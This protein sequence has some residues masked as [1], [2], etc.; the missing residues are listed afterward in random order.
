[1]LVTIF[2]TLYDL[3]IHLLSYTTVVVSQ[4][5]WWKNHLIYDILKTEH[6]KDRW[7]SPYD[8]KY[9]LKAGLFCLACPLWFGDIAGHIN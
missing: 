4:T 3:T 2:K 7:K 6:F 8:K 5:D 9:I 1:M